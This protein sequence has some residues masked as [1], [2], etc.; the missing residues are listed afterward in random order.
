MHIIVA[1]PTIIIRG[2][3]EDKVVAIVDL[4]KECRVVMIMLK[5]S[6]KMAVA[7]V[8]RVAL[9]EFTS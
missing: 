7:A 5:S 3:E 8:V 4:K 1:I 2:K 6:I 9:L